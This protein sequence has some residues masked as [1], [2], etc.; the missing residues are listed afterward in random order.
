MT[1]EPEHV[2][3]FDSYSFS[4][5]LDQN[6]ANVLPA[7][8]QWMIARYRAWVKTHDRYE[9][10]THLVYRNKRDRIT[11]WMGRSGEHYRWFMK[12]KSV[13]LGTPLTNR[14]VSWISEQE[15]DP[16]FWDGM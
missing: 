12:G 2:K 4:V 6:G 11:R 14:E 8:D 1:Q 13:W 15:A 7:T 9:C 10:M 3:D 5:W 16:G